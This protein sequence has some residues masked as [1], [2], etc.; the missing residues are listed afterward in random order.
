MS[1]NVID[2]IKPKNNGAF[3]VVEAADIA[4]SSAKRLPEALA[5]KADV[6]DLN[7]TNIAVAAKA[8]AAETVETTTSLQ[9][10]INNIVSPVTEDA[11]VINA[12]VGADGTSYQ[13]LKARLDAENSAMSDLIS[14]I[15]DE[16]STVKVDKSYTADNGGFD[17]HGYIEG[18]G[19]INNVQASVRTD[20]VDLTGYKRISGVGCINNTSYLLGFFDANKTFIPSISVKGKYSTPY[21]TYFDIDITDPEYAS[22]K[23]CMVCYYDDD[24]E[25]FLELQTDSALQNLINETEKISTKTEDIQYRMETA[26]IVGYYVNTEGTFTYNEKCVRTDYVDISGFKKI[27]CKGNINNTGYIVA[28]FDAGHNIMHDISVQ[29]D[30]YASQDFVEVDLSLPEYADAKYA[31]ASGHDIDAG[32]KK[33]FIELYNTESVADSIA[34]P[35]IGKKI[36][37][38]GDSITSRNYTVPTWWQQIGM[39]TGAI[40]YSYGVSGSA[41]SD[42]WS[43]PDSF[44]D[45][46][47]RMEKDADCVF[48]MGGTNDGGVRKG[49]WDSEDTSTIYGALN[50]IIT[51]LLQN[52]PGKRILFATPIPKQNS[53]ETNVENP[54]ALFYSKTAS[55]TLQL[56]MIVCAIKAKCKQYSIPCLDLYYE[57]GINGADEGAIY[58]RESDILHPS[59][60]GHAQMKLKIQEFLEKEI[61]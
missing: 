54:E 26:S 10:Q 33:C 39:E 16:L 9:N 8:D 58:Y 45:R 13:T 21:K 2:T 56:E 40:F 20:Y 48:V 19:T 30:E 43:S 34:S 7:A 59:S 6:T 49:A 5:E 11:E 38:L 37:L 24:D 36:C 42:I 15:S 1:V 27:R 17:L 12:R 47:S 52:Y 4:V 53:F 61:K 32:G 50:Y 60:A 3:P 35:I 25:C 18:N 23:Y 55:D 57:S 31:I 22:A 44:C 29:G 28:F 41:I 51:Y 46:V 14:D